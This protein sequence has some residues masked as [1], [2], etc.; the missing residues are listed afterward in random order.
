MRA[1]LALCLQRCWKVCS[2]MQCLWC[3]SQSRWTVSNKH[4]RRNEIVAS[5][6]E[7]RRETGR[8]SASFCLF[9]SRLSQTVR[10]PPPVKVEDSRPLS[11]L[12]PGALQRRHH[13]WASAHA[14]WTL[15]WSDQDSKELRANWQRCVRLHN[16]RDYLCGD[17]FLWRGGGGVH[18]FFSCTE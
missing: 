13:S 16:Q 14:R 4:H 8:E 17:F 5:V 11:D 9:G 2:L 1:T 10:A 15:F 6:R 3:N 7:R 18:L 12:L